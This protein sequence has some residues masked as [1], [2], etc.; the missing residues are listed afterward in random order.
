MTYFVCEIKFK[1]F[2]SGGFD[3]DLCSAHASKGNR[4]SF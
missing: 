3:T 2:Y 4:G 1:Y